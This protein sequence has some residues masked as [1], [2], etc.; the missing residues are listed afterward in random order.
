M[1]VKVDGRP[2]RDSMW[3]HKYGKDNYW[4]GE[5]MVWQTLRIATPIFQYAF[6]EWQALF[7][8]DN[9][10]NYYCFALVASN[11]SLNPGGRQP[12]LRDGFDHTGRLPHPLVFLTTNRTSH[13][14]VK[15]KPLRLF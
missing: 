4:T 7:T 1:W 8:F 15:S 13:F 6:P 11:I 2:V 3:L 5:K 9:A 12:H 10:S 14:A